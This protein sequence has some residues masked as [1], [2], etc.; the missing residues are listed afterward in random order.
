[1]SALV[2]TLLGIAAIIAAGILI[3]CCVVLAKWHD[4]RRGR[5]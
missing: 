3:Y 4:A 5:G 2:G 1:V